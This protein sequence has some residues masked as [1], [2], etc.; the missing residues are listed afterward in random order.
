YREAT[1]V[2]FLS[3][4]EGF[5]LPIAEAASF[6]RFVV[7]SQGNQAG[8]EAGGSA[9]ITV[10]PDQPREAAEKVIGGLKE[11]QLAEISSNLPKW[12]TAAMA[13]ADAINELNR[14]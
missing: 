4:R 6:G 14:E 7:V 5:G 2:V 1:A 13:Y 11:K 3:D 10:N 9:I 12:E 8:L